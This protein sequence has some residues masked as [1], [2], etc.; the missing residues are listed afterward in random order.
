MCVAVL[1]LWGIWECVSVV[2][3]WIINANNEQR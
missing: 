3:R 2:I 1:V